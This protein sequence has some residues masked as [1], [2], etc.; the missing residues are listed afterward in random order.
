M[1]AIV[2]G[3]VLLSGVANAWECNGCGHS[4]EPTYEVKQQNASVDYNTPG[5]LQ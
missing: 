4:F 3:L 5:Y 1:R 2:L